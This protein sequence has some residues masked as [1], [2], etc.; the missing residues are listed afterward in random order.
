MECF[1]AHAD[2]ITGGEMFYTLLSSSNGQYRYNITFK[3]FMD[4]YSQRQFNNPATIG[5]FNRQSH[6]RF[7]EMP[8]SLTSTELLNLTNTGPCI[9]D[10]PPV[11]YRVG[12]YNFTITL[13][14]SA[15]GYLLTCMVNYRI[16]GIS[17]LISEYSN[18]GATYTGE[19][20]GTAQ[21]AGAPANN[22]A[23]FTGSD[24]VVVCANNTL[25][26]S[27]AA[28]DPDGDQLRY[29]F[30]DA[31]QSSGNLGN[32]GTGSPGP[33]PYQSV[34]YGHPFN[35]SSPLGSTIRIDPNTGLITGIAP[36]N[37]IYVV[38]VSVQEIRNNVVIATQR[39]DLQ[40][41]ITA[42]SIASASLPDAYM[43]C[44]NSMTIELANQSN[45]PLI[46]TQHWEL[47]NRQGQVLFSS[48]QASASFTFPDTGLYQVKLVINRGDDCADSSKAP[49]YVYPGFHPAFSFT[50][51]CI[52]KPTLFTNTTST[53]WGALSASQW[54]F[55]EPAALDD[56]SSATNPSYTYPGLGLKRVQ[57]I[58]HNSN[59]CI[60][61]TA[62][63]I[64]IVDK[65]PILLAFRD[66]LICLSD[67]LQ[68]RA[69]GAGQYQWSPDEDML[70]AQTATPLVSPVSTTK[71]YVELEDNGC[72][73]TDSV[74]V[75]VVDH[76][77]LQLM[78]DT[79]ICQADTI[80][81][82]L[83]SD[84]LQ[85]SWTPAAQLLDPQAPM[86]LAVTAAETRYQV[87]AVIGGCSS[88]GSVTVSTVPYPIADAGPDQTICYAA[89]TQL[90]AQ[91]DGSS[92]RWLPA[93][94]LSNTRSL[95]PIARPASTTAYILEA[96]DIKGCPKPG[97]D[98]IL[99]T[100][101]PKIFPF[102]GRDTTAIIGQPLQL[103]ASGGTSYQWW[104]ATGLSA[105]NIANP[106]ARYQQ[107]SPGI[108]YK[109]W[110]WD[111]AGCVDSTY[112]LV[113]VFNTRPSVFVPNAFTPNG[114]GRNDRFR[115]VAAGMQRIHFFRI[116]NR[117]GQLVYSAA[118]SQ[119][120]WDGAVGGKPQEAGSY[121]WMIQAVDYTGAP[122]FQKGTM[123]LIR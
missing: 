111:E 13:P 105:T 68:L 46:R 18:I 113:R 107:S 40:I 44:R 70:D 23:K 120:G 41:K 94:S 63:T 88:S 12:Y 25:L 64:Q 95:Q 31:W 118:D 122:Y 78:P 115:F 81:L 35:G 72:R 5:V 110:V 103:Q 8:V 86:P 112:L 48:A 43:L 7:T 4:C 67:Q 104:P 2:H 119:P 17:N 100:V 117:W 52:S 75:R 24:L 38:T 80:R 61:T 91:T 56:F 73:N 76:V 33:P 109:V 90:R 106:I 98:T 6:T 51:I 10:P 3:L 54:D 36:G 97:R 99:V 1:Y 49:A 57:L 30:S 39:K 93:G 16:N 121:V 58:A 116:F 20:P 69:G 101:L 96:Y 108:Q 66:T 85:Y 102:A 83:Q 15:E 123:T 87:T 55:G 29:S 28:T 50:G 59:G 37:G 84:G 32:G 42:C 26:Y 11:C 77:S 14:A 92:V 45:S 19:I 89:S 60:D 74:Q 114:D 34:P 53:I 79:S 22:S 9:T 21:L 62:Q 27:F 71:Y 65:P 47:S 82:R